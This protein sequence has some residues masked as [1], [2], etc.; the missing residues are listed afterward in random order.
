MASVR[1]FR[2]VKTIGGL[3]ILGGPPLNF[4]ANHQQPQ[5]P[6]SRTEPGPPGPNSAFLGVFSKPTVEVVEVAMEQQPLVEEHAD[7]DFP[8]S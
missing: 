8:P 4:H 7:D 3:S 1:V 2:S 5:P 6:F